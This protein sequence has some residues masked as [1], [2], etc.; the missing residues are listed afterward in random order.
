MRIRLLGL[1][2]AFAVAALALEARTVEASDGMAGAEATLDVRSCTTSANEVV[3]AS[4]PA[5]AV[6][7]VEMVA[8]D[9]CF[10]SNCPSCGGA[11]EKACCD[12]TC[13][14]VCGGS[15]CAG[16]GCGAES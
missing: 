14:C 6:D 9:C 3:I 4:A 11:G 13:N 16:Q 1:I 10:L 15:C 8:V 5:F 7:K 2:C 12:G